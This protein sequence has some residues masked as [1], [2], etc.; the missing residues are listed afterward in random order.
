MGDRIY[1][2]ES[3]GFFKKL[4]KECE[5]GH[6]QGTSEIVSL[7]SKASA[8]G[9]DLKRLESS[10]KEVAL[11]SHIDSSTAKAFVVSGWEGRT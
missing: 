6:T 5:Q 10:I 1:C 4:H 11:S 8:V 7:V 9:T 2:G 3:A